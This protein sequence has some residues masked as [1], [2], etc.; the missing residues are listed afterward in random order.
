MK[1]QS[2]PLP[3]P[4]CGR[5]IGSRGPDAP[6]MNPLKDQVDGLAD[7][8]RKVRELTINRQSAEHAMLLQAESVLR[9]VAF[10]AETHK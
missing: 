1:K 2:K 4:F 9:A 10:L 5:T 6:S 8:V 7:T 3:C